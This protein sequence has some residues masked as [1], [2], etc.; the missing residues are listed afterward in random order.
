[1]WRGG[2][3]PGWN[4]SGRYSAAVEDAK[5]T[6]AEDGKEAEERDETEAPPPSME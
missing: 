2:G 1:M 5:G 6:A 4:P 3:G